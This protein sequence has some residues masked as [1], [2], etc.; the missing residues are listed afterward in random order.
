METSIDLSKCFSH[1]TE[2]VKR[3]FGPES[4]SLAAS[5]MK[6][7]EPEKYNSLKV[8]ACYRDRIVPEASLPFKSRVSRADLD[9]NFRKTKAQESDGLVPVADELADRLGIPRGTKKRYEDLKNLIAG[10]KQ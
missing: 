3:I 4:D 1:P 10:G 7:L 8:A 6:R 9:E 5:E 2:E